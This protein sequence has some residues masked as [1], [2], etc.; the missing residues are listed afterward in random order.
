MTC[1]DWLRELGPHLMVLAFWFTSLAVFEWVRK[2]K[3]LTFWLFMFCA[4]AVWL[5]VTG[6][7]L[8]D[9]HQKDAFLTRKAEVMD[10]IGR[11]I[12]I[13]QGLL[14]QIAQDQDYM[15]PRLG[16]CNSG[17][18]VARYAPKIED[19]K[20]RSQKLLDEVLPESGALARFQTV[21][22][23][24]PKSDCPKMDFNYWKLLAMTQNLI[25][26]WEATEQYRLRV[27]PRCRK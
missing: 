19:W 1:L 2:A 13:G 5:V 24:F 12:K 9:L 26:I 15:N 21:P 14:H 22:E 7:K 23:S 11:E 18:V 10:A 16:H 8:A 4:L 6:V 3:P 25:Y 20:S 17:P 27:G